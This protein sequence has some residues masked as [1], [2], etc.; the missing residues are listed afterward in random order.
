MEYALAHLSTDQDY[1]WFVTLLIW[2][3]AALIWWRGGRDLPGWRWLPWSAAAGCLLAAIEIV[4]FVIPVRPLPGVPPH[5]LTE[6]LMTGAAAVGIAGMIWSL[7]GARRP[8]RLV[9]VLALAGTVAMSWF[10]PELAAW[11]LA[12]A[13]VGSVAAAWP[14]LSWSARSA[15][16]LVAIAGWLSG[17]GPLANE[18]EMTRRWNTI[19][20]ASIVWSVAQGVAA[21]FALYGIWRATSRAWVKSAIKGDGRI[22][23]WLAGGWLASGLI[24]ATVAGSWARKNFE[25]SVLARA[26]VAASLMDRASVARLLQPDFKV[27]EIGERRQPSGKITRFA[28]VPALLTPTSIAV[29]RQLHAIRQANPDAINVHLL[30]LREGHVL[31]LPSATIRNYPAHAAVAEPEAIVP[32]PEWSRPEGRYQ[33]P[34]PT[35]FGV[36]T[37]ARAPVLSDTGQLL[38]WIRLEFPVGSWVASQAQARLQMFAIV[39]LGVGV[40]ALA[41]LQRVQAQ[42]H[43]IARNEALEASRADQLKT[44]FLAKVSHELRTPIQSILGYGELLRGSVTE[45][46]ARSRLD[47]QR[48]HGELMLRL[49]NDLLDLSAIQAGAFRLSAKPAP[50]IE[51]VQQAAESLAFRAATKGVEFSFGADPAVAVWANIDRERVRQ[52]VLNLVSN[53]IKFTER[54]KI[55]VILRPGPKPD[56]AMLVVRDTG[57]GIAIHEQA[58]L[59][60]PFSRLE[61]TATKEGAGLG[62]ALTAALCQSMGGGISVQSAPGE[63]AC[64]SAH[65]LAP[66]CPMPCVLP[67]ARADSRLGGLRIVVADDNTLVR[68]LF[69]AYLEEGGA[70]CYPALDGEMAVAVCLREHPD[71]I[72][73]DLSMPRCDG[74]EAARILRAQ[75]GQTLRIVAVSAHAAHHEHEAALAAGA[76]SFLPKPVALVELAAALVGPTASAATGAHVGRAELMARLNAQF[77]REAATQYRAVQEALA[78]RDCAAVRSCAHYLKNSAI[79]VGDQALFEACS[80][81]ESAA[82]RADL[83][84]LDLAWER[85]E[86]ALA[87]WLRPDPPPFVGGDSPATNQQ[88]PNLSSHA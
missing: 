70:V 9:A 7:S 20:T 71:A 53:A 38:G 86:R 39:L 13:A 80:G 1:F 83:P 87:V 24:L 22:F 69:V 33:R 85:C 4:T 79:V 73:L 36:L 62:L 35:P 11:A 42:Q 55:E 2:S 61:A 88:R 5:W 50:L 30:V 67:A 43:E 45:P 48:Q 26:K 6:R 65:W 12:G 49:V 10:D 84:A 16:A 19:S 82:E 8:W 72:V 47:A 34:L 29:R 54:G 74:H 27:A 3:A 23:L 15:T 14:S 52:V 64:F 44:T 37:D 58:N 51:L 31:F 59:F 18:L 17:W 28:V 32:L 57:P 46:L 25:T 40:A 81:L 76:D 77:R 78:A 68:E 60:Q 63:G 21:L 75:L 66:A 41:G 56:T